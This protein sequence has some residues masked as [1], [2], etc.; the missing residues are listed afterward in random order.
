MTKVPDIPSDLQLTKEEKLEYL[1]EQIGQYKKVMYRLWVDLK[2]AREYI[3]IGKQRDDDNFR[4]VGKMKEQEYG[5]EMNGA[6]ETATVLKAIRDE[7][8]K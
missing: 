7:L 5:A 8:E 4:Q 6:V 1:D 3:R 2:V